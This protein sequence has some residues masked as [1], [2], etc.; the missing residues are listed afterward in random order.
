MT[1]TLFI[2]IAIVLMYANVEIQKQKYRN[3]D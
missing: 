1:A 2:A 3:N